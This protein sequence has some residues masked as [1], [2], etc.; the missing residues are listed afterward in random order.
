MLRTDALDYELSPELIATHPATPRDAARLLVA[1][2]GGAVVSHGQV[3][4]LAAF[5]RAG[6]VLVLNNTRVLPARFAGSRVDTGGRVTGLYLGPGPEPGTWRCMLKARRFREGARVEL[7]DREGRPSGEAIEL[8]ARHDDPDGGVVWVVRVVSSGGDVLERVGLTPLP[9]YILAARERGEG[10]G[11]ADADDESDR[12]DYQ[13]VFA[14]DPGSVA[15][16][17]AGLHFTPEL[18]ASLDRVGVERVEVTLHVG[19]GTFKPIESETVEAHPMH[20][21]W[22]SMDAGAIKRVQRAKAEGRRVIAVGTTS[23][24]TL[25]SYAEAIEAGGSVASG[26]SA[27]SFPPAL[28]TRLLITPGYRWRWVDGLMTNFHLPRST[29]LAMVAAL[30]EADGLAGIQGRGVERLLEL[31]REAIGEQYRFYSF[32]DA[33]LLLP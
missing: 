22:C 8:V 26:A 17:T 4:D 3:R 24:R 1:G 2:R 9:P 31:Y 6:D 10:A 27:A 25:E 7:D 19:M 5:L 33:M 13:T 15:A 28:E 12:A 23:A 21:E 14:R 30:L 32:G 29:L 11:R 18:L 16:P 20:A